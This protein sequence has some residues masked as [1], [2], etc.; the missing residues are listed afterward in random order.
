MSDKINLDDMKKRMDGALKNLQTE[1]SGLRTGRASAHLLDPIEVDAYGSRVPLN[2]VASVSVPEARMLSVQVWDK[3]MVSAV[4]KA[5]RSS[6][7]GL[8]P[9]VDGTLLRL[10]IPELSQDRRKELSK[11]A[12]KYAENTRIAIRNIRRDTIDLVKKLEKSSEVSEDHSKKYQEDIQKATD[13]FI[14][15]VDEALKAKEVDIM[16]V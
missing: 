11:I 16:K 7:L 3:G 13:D 4:D 6:G 8:N 1:F 5:I 10:P 12:A 2:Q 14:K 15:K 9:Q